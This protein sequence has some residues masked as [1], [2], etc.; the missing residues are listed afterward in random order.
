MKNI[1]KFPKRLHISHFVKKFSYKKN[2]SRI[3]STALHNKTGSFHM[4][5]IFFLYIFI[6]KIT[7]K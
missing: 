5:S 7:V 4:G 2:I 3:R 1:L 6:E